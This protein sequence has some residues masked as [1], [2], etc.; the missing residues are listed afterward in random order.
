[1]L[2]WQGTNVVLSQKYPKAAESTTK[3]CC[4]LPLLKNCCQQNCTWCRGPHLFMHPGKQEMHTASCFTKQLQ[5]RL[6]F[7]IN[8]PFCELIQSSCHFKFLKC[9]QL[10]HTVQFTTGRPLLMWLCNSIRGAELLETRKSSSNS[11]YVAK[12]EV[13]HNFKLTNDARGR[14]CWVK[15]ISASRPCSTNAW[16]R[17]KRKMG[18]HF[19]PYLLLA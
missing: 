16:C 12:S 18:F 17:S 14:K 13:W 1:M 11:L 5:W 10:H 8:T 15:Q 4:I 2:R 6:G 19:W 7:P 3:T 9:A